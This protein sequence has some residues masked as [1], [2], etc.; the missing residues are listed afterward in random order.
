MREDLARLIRTGS[1]ALAALAVLTALA[2][3]TACSA[4][5][6]NTAVS[7]E[8]LASQVKTQLG[9]QFD[10]EPEKITC[11]DDL[12]AEVGAEVRCTLEDQGVKI[13]VSVTA[14][15]VEGTHVTFDAQV[16]DKPMS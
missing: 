6:G 13:G 11:P 2:F 16:D 12:K 14:T 3:L 1:F 4:S 10:H 7:G 9:K 5:V 15:K 8:K